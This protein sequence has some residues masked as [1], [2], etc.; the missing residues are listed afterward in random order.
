MRATPRLTRPRSL[1][2]PK[3]PPSPQAVNRSSAPQVVRNWS[4]PKAGSLAGGSGGDYRIGMHSVTFRHLH[5]R[6][7][8]SLRRVLPLDEAPA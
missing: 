7:V 2:P 3:P 1:S 4:L 8:D 6:D 5:P